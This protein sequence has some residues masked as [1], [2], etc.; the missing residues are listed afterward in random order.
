AI[1]Q[2]FAK[3]LDRVGL[4]GSGTAPEPRGLL[5]LTGVNTVTQGTDGTALADYSPI[6]AGIRAILDEDGPTPTAAIMAPRTLVD[7]AGLVDSTGQPLRAPKLAEDVSI[8]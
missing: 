2:A 1:A 8:I 7:F 6:L 4:M 5:N 3:E